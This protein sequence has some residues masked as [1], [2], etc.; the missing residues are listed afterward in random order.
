MRDAMLARPPRL[1]DGLIVRV[2]D[3]VIDERG[4][5][6]TG[7]IRLIVTTKAY[8]HGDAMT[9]TAGVFQAVGKSRPLANKPNHYAT[10]VIHVA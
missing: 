5:V 10:T 8:R 7:Q 2:D 4:P 9:L 3:A 6:E 1:C